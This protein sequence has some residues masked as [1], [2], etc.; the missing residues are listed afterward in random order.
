MIVIALKTAH[1]VAL[2]LWAGGLIALPPLL[3]RKQELANRA[4]EVR[5]H[6]FTRFAYDAIVSPAAL[7]AIGTGT[8]LIFSG[9]MLGDWLFLKLV[10]V[11]GMGGT[12]MMIGR[13]LDQLEAPEAKPTEVRRI[14]LLV[15]AIIF[16]TLTLW[17]VLDRPVVDRDMFPQWMLDG[18]DKD[19]P[20]IGEAGGSGSAAAPSSG[21]MAV[22]T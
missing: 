18:Q 17:L 11:A 19:L 6:H 4:V 20:F 16:V 15:A 13:V 14:S 8:A 9:V 21:A 12:H 1:I 2:T 7:V 5:L 10:A 3:R 22:P